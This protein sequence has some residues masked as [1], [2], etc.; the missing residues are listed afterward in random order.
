MKA[1]SCAFHPVFSFVYLAFE[2]GST[3]SLSSSLTCQ[4]TMLLL[5]TF[6]IVE[7]CLLIIHISESILPFQHFVASILI[8]KSYY[9]DSM[10]FLTLNM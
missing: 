6:V 5:N 7:R 2:G 4:P 8:K 9:K 1:G 10:Y 3:G